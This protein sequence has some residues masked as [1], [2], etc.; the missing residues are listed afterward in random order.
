MDDGHLV[1]RVDLKADRS[2]NTLLLVAAFGEPDAPR[3]RVAAALAGE[4]ESITSWL[5][6]SGFSVLGRGDLAGELSAA[7]G[8]AG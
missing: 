6:L 7:A 2:S 3:A 1:A 8:R 4:L 5:G